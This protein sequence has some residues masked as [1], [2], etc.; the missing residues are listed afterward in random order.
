MQMQIVINVK[1]APTKRHIIR[2]RDKTQKYHRKIA[3]KFG[4]QSIGNTA[5]ESE[6]SKEMAIFGA[7]I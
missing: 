4:S 2:L 6:L 5:G 3:P 1:R 7:I